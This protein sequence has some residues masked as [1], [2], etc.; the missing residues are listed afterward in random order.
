MKN[1]IELFSGLGKRLAAFGNDTASRAAIEQAHAENGWFSPDE[2]C[3]AVGALADRMLR[4]DTLRAWLAR[5]P[6]PVARPRRVLVVMAGNIPLVG[7]A[8]LLCVVAAGDRCLIKPSS[9]D[10]V[11]IEYVVRLLRE[12]DPDV[13]IEFSDGNPSGIDAVIATGSDNANRTFR[14]RYAS[15]PALLRGSRHSAAVLSGHETPE[16]LQ[17]LADDMFA[18]SGLG[19][20]SVSLLFLPRGY[21]LRLQPPVMNDKYRH[22]Y[23]QAKAV[24]A[25]QGLPFRDLGTALLIEERSFPTALSCIHCAR[26][27]SLAEVEAWL[28]AHDAELQCVVSKALPHPRRVGFGEAQRPGPTDYADDCDVMRFLTE[29]G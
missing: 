5:Y 9:K 12:A 17:A 10:R 3:R 24:L 13:P 22:N 6:V 21:D 19:C 1:A 26:Y 2:I 7:F 4:P 20:R 15:L 23:L 18:Y 25:M 16:E 11:L 27:D 14:S 8:D 29:L 28:A